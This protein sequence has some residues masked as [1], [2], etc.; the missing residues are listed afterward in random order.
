MRFFRLLKSILWRSKD[1]SA[2]ST[3]KINSILIV[4]LTALGDQ[5]F[6][7]AMITD[8][9]KRWPQ[10]HIDWVVD[11]QFQAIP[12]LSPD[13]RFIHAVPLKS[14]AKSWYK[15]STWDALWQFIQRLRQQRYDLCIDAQGLWKSSLITAFSRHQSCVG[16]VA[17]ACGESP[18]AWFYDRH[19]APQSH[20]H[21]AERLRA[22]AAFAADTNTNEA[23][24]FHVV[25]PHLDTKKVLLDT[26]GRPIA[27]L[28][29]SASKAHKLWT[30]AHWAALA[31]A[32]NQAGYVCY[33]S[34]GNSD[35]RLNATEIIEAVGHE[36]TRLL[37]YTALNDWPALLSLSALVVGVDTGLL[38][39]ANVMRIPCVGLFINERSTLFPFS[40]ALSIERK[41]VPNNDEP[42]PNEVFERLKNL[43]LAHK[44]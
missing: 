4:K 27:I 28:L 13:L 33:V 10:A 9:K 36:C 26:G 31:Q 14:Y 1:M 44:V 37:P 7:M 17:D 40:W 23:I 20:Q 19:F 5:L 3:G 32:L 2:C 42:M 21:G 38:H 41:V 11:S 12:A 39:L 24:S 43:P 29:V 22:L 16:F 34:W 15:L 6:A 18:A 35:E 25:P 30:N 8:L